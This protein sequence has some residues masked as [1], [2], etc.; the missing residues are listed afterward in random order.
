MRSSSTASTRRVPADRRGVSGPVTSGNVV[1][2]ATG[3][4]LLPLDSDLR[5]RVAPRDPIARIS[6]LFPLHSKNAQAA[7]QKR[8]LWS[9]EA[10]G[11]SDT[12]LLGASA[13]RVER[14]GR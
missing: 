13:A 14:S 8:P 1:V 6:P 11:S 5:T 4:L 12:H 10:T 7:E 9:S 2:K 3:P